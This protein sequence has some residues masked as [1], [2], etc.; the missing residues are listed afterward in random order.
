LFL[1]KLSLSLSQAAGLR[2]SLSLPVTVTTEL[3]C[4]VASTRQVEQTYK[5]RCAGGNLGPSRI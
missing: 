3:S 5:I 2:L 1:I 4:F